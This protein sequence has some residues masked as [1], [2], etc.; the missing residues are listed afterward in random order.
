MADKGVGA[1]G[2][3][4]A[5]VCGWTGSAAALLRPPRLGGLGCAGTGTARLSSVPRAPLALIH[6]FKDGF[7][8]LCCGPAAPANKRCASGDPAQL[9]CPSGS[10]QQGQS[11]ARFCRQFPLGLD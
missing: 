9:P 5:G 3:G 11:S 8:Q 7:L 6:V 10:A 2:S 1:W 4:G